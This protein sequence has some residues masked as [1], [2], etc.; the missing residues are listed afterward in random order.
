MTMH[1]AVKSFVENV[2]RS[3][4]T[5]AAASFT[6]SRSRRRSGARP[7]TAREARRKCPAAY[8]PIARS[9]RKHPSQVLPQSLEERVPVNKHRSG[10]PTQIT[11]ML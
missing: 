6:F 2:Y 8:P 5:R 4:S 10:T 11:A 1:A 3:H 9:G 7:L